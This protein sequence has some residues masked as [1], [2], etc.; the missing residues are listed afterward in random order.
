M[1]RV[2]VVRLGGVHGEVGLVQEIVVV[3][4]DLLSYY[5]W[6]VVI[7]VGGNS[8]RDI[9]VVGA[10][11][12]RGGRNYDLSPLYMESCFRYLFPT[13]LFLLV[14]KLVAKSLIG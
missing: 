3:V 1:L 7:V 4:F 8:R 6:Y 13:I 14:R 12:R 9:E 5:R 2:V 10:E 11:I